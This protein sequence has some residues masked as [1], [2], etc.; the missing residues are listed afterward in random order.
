M[1]ISPLVWFFSQSLYY[2]KREKEFNILQSV[3]A[4]GSEIRSIYIQGGLS[5]ATL[6]LIVSIALSY[7]GSYALFYLYN[8]VMPNFT[9][10]NIRYVFYM[11]WYAIVTSVVMSVACGFL[12]AYFPYR[13]YA[14]YRSSL[15]NG[16]AGAEYGDDE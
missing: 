8:V 9:G 16:G 7:L 13:S 11:P 12:S 6:S 5:M 4:I 1:C 2:K 15:Q 10:E 14:K 3:G